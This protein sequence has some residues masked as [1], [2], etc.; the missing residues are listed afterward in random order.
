MVLLVSRYPKIWWKINYI[1][2]K[3][4]QVNLFVSFLV[5]LLWLQSLANSALHWLV[6]CK[7]NAFPLP[8]I[9]T[10]GCDLIRLP[11]LAFADDSFVKP[12]LSAFVFFHI[13]G[14]IEKILKKKISWFYKKKVLRLSKGWKTKTICSLCHFGSR[15]VKASRVAL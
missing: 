5:L 10:F 2:L 13:Y 8:V 6:G 7:W 15:L 14:E 4:E 1:L 12:C 3:T 9:S 11:Y